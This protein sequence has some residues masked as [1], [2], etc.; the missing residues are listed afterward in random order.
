[1]FW[2]IYKYRLKCLTRSRQMMFWTLLFPI[3]LGTLFYM[4]FS[5]LSSVEAF[6][7]IKIAVVDNEEFQKDTNFREALQSASDPDNGDGSLFDVTYTS[8]EEGES[9][10]MGGNIEGIIYFNNGIKL[11]LKE[12]GLNQTII[13]EFI[14]HYKQ[15]LSTVSAIINRN[16]EAM[17]KGL[18]ESST[19]H[20]DFLKEASAGSSAPDTTVNYFY[21][22]IAMAC[23]YGSFFGLNEVTVN[24]ANLSAQAAR[25]NMSPVHKLRVFIYSMTAAATIQLVNIGILLLY[26]TVILHINFGTQITYILLTCIAGTVTGVTFG[27]FIGSIVKGGEGIKIGILIA[28]SMTMSFLSGMM[29]DK[30]KY[31]VNTK[32]PV[33]GYLNPANLITDC[34]YSLYY[35]DTYTVFFT[36][37]LFLILLTAFFSLLTYLQI[38]RQKYASL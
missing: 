22:L 28:G 14:D 2:H 13:K 19:S 31:I 29:Y 38:R 36:D 24:Q 11:I 27:A 25:A 7:H 1:M 34:F 20:K 6:S 17:Q 12:S 3:I 10:L 4:A 18:I 21:T 32:V 30:M 16:P 37:I 9:L 5:N 35:Y 33:L 23:L 26:L 8:K 15:T